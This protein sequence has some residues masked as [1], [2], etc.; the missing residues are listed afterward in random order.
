MEFLDAAG[1]PAERYLA[2]ARFSPRVAEDPEGLVPLRQVLE[3]VDRTANDEGAENI[4]LL[5]AD[6][7]GLDGLGALGR[8]IRGSATV[9]DAIASAAAH[10]RHYNS[11]ERIWL[12]PEDDRV[13][14]CHALDV[15][16]ATGERHGNLFAVMLLIKV[17]RMAAGPKWWPGE[18]RL[19]VT[20]TQRLKRYEAVLAADLVLHAQPF[21]AIVLDRPLLARA[22]IDSG[23][24][25]KAGT[26][27]AAFLRSSAPARD[28]S[29]SV[30]QAIGG[31][32]C[33]GYPDVRLAA[34]LAGLSARTFMRRLAEEGTSYERLVEQARF[35]AA[36][37]LLRGDEL[38]L[39]DIAYE[40]GYTDPANFSRAFRRW[41]G[42][43]PSEYRRHCAMGVIPAAP[44][45]S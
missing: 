21:Y 25:G 37:D 19:P 29:T 12:L 18:I 40:L 24:P 6:R 9:R 23:E 31:L 43:P 20:E 38:K 44:A 10:I 27:D 16:G 22:V 30:R 33:G 13:L 32:L 11:A 28:L 36:V 41:A 14:V 45:A 8:V 1:A 7:T 15:P 39:I 2:A 35:E 26:A 5:V 34:D 4:A 17:I 3:F 42:M